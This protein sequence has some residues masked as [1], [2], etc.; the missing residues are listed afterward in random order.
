[1]KFIFMYH[2]DHVTDQTELY[3]SVYTL[4]MKQK[5]S[6]FSGKVHYPNVLFN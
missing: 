6:Y 2:Y 4:D 5:Y 1:M 3:I